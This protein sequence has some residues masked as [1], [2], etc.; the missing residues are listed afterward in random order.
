M[1]RV[2]PALDYETHGNGNECPGEL[3]VVPP[4]KLL[5]VFEQHGTKLIIMADITGILRFKA[6]G[7][8]HGRERFYYRD[9]EDK[10][11]LDRQTTH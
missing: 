11:K 4:R 10:L 9:I 2:I 5:N 6:Y 1:I 8:I 7:L 3:M